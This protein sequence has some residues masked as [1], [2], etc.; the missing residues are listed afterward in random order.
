MPDDNERR[1]GKCCDGIK[2]AL[3][4]S[5]RA[6][7]QEVA[8]D[9]SA[10]ACQHAEQRGHQWVQAERQVLSAVPATA[11]SARPAASKTKIGVCSREMGEYQ[12]KIVSPA[13]IATVQ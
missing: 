7:D 13:T 5:R 10:D 6:S 3:K 12:K 8:H 1:A 2:V 4:H 11:K 9:A